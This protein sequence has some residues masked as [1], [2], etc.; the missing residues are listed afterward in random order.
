MSVIK[1]QERKKKTNP[2]LPVIG[3]VLAISIGLLAYGLSTFLIDPLIDQFPELQT[4]IAQEPDSKLYIQAGIGILLWFTGF[5]IAMSLVSMNMAHNIV[6]DEY[7]MMIPVNP[8]QKDIEN[9]RKALSKNRQD[10][11]KA[12]KRLKKKKEREASH[13]R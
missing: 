4:R 9:Y 1:Q 10:K 3:L 2:Y 12:A 7:N 6:E 5:V 8:T 11:I 13:R